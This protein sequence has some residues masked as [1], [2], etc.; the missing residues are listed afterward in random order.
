M[1]AKSMK[2]LASV[3][4]KSIAGIKIPDPCIRMRKGAPEEFA[5]MFFNPAGAFDV[6]IGT[7]L[8]KGKV[9]KKYSKKPFKKYCLI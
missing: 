7:I 1:P 8:K 3:T 5:K 4:Y 2:G 6:E 9:K